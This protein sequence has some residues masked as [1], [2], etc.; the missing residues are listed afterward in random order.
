M[1]NTH[2]QEKLLEEDKVDV[3]RARSFTNP[4]ANRLRHSNRT[5]ATRK[6]S[7]AIIKANKTYCC[8]VCDLAYGKNNDFAKH[9]TSKRPVTQTL[10]GAVNIE[11]Y[12]RFYL[13]DT[14]KQECINYPGTDGKV[15]GLGE[16][17]A[18]IHA[19]LLDSVQKTCSSSSF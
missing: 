8:E 17:E 9:K 19:I 10:Y 4:N 1:Y 12:T 15:Y 6:N 16:D 5:T 2:Y 18:K 11:T 14:Y 7:L 3:Y 13:L